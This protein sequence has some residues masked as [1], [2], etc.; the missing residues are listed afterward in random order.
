MAPRGIWK[1]ASAWTSRRVRACDSSDGR[2]SI[3]DGWA[4]GDT[5]IVARAAEGRID[6]RVPASRPPRIAVL[7]RAPRHVSAVIKG[8]RGI[9]VSTKAGV[10]LAARE[11]EMLTAVGN[12]WKPLPQ[13]M[14]RS[15]GPADPSGRTHAMLGATH[16]AV[17]DPLLVSLDGKTRATTAV[18]LPVTGAARY[19]VSVS[20]TDGRVVRTFLTS[21]HMAKL[22]NL[23]PGRYEV[24]AQAVDA[25]GLEG[26]GSTPDTVRVVGVE[27]PAGSFVSDGTV[28]LAHDQRAHFTYVDGVEVSYDAATTY[29][30][31]PSDIGLA[32]G[33]ATHV[34]FREAGSNHDAATVKL[35]PRALSA[36]IE[37]GPR[38]ARWPSDT[39]TVTVRVV[40]WKGRPVPASTKLEARVQINVTPVDVQWTRRGNVMSGV[41][42]ASTQPGPWVIRVEVE[43][44][45]GESLGR[46]FLEVAPSPSQVA[47]R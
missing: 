47:S 25:F 15:I 11:G 5:G 21:T 43:D 14:V 40:D 34:R 31:A 18:W 6:V 46:N 28:L 7:V 41:V 9:V 33:N 45:F 17:S 4:A 30:A 2:V 36:D 22:D 26:P 20:R 12:D 37:I 29:I 3:W 39:V 19:R 16:L 23:A 10:A 42:P 27:L 35:A 8:G 44:Q 38:L 1:T 32:R 13:G 24:R